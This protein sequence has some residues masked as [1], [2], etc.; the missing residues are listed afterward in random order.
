MTGTPKILYV[1]LQSF[2][3]WKRTRGIAY[4]KAF[5]ID[6]LQTRQRF[7]LEC[8]FS[9]ARK[10]HGERTQEKDEEKHNSGKKERYFNVHSRGC[11]THL[12]FK[13]IKTFEESEMSW[14][15]RIQTSDLENGHVLM[16]ITFVL[17]LRCFYGYKISSYLIT[18]IKLSSDLF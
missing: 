16:A 11:Y 1:R 5:L 8:S 14:Y 12:S 15:S 17:I 9:R 3:N 4:T 7:F 2:V 6:R 13:F 18:P 10:K